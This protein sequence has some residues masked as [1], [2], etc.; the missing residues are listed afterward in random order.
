M[1]A[2][3]VECSD[4]DVQYG[5]LTVE[6]VS[7]KEVQDK[8]YEIKNKFYDEGFED[9]TVADVLERFPMEWDWSYEGGNDYI[10]EI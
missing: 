8:I 7:V 2:R 5:I 10:I 4:Y 1:V 3:L 6:N 9:W